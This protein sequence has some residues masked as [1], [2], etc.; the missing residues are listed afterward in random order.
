L[1]NRRLTHCLQYHTDIT[2]FQYRFLFLLPSI[3]LAREGARLTLSEVCRPRLTVV[4][5][6]SRWWQFNRVLNQDDYPL[7]Q[8]ELDYGN[9]FPLAAFYSP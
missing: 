4:S 5:R 2:L 7:I 9:S 6:R 8:V 3:I 1:H